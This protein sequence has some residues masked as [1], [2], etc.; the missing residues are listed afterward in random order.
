MFDVSQFLFQREALSLIGENIVR[1][2]AHFCDNFDEIK[3]ACRGAFRTRAWWLCLV[4]C[5]PVELLESSNKSLSMSLRWRFQLLSKLF[6][7][8]YLRFDVIK[9]LALDGVRAVGS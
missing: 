1:I 3:L 9:C 8:N 6:T 5:L 4:K 2:L 7:V